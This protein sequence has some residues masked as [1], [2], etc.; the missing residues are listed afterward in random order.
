MMATRW[1]LRLRASATVRSCD[2]APPP[3]RGVKL[4]SSTM[5]TDSGL[6][7]GLGSGLAWSPWAARAS[8]ASSC[9]DI[10]AQPQLQ[11]QEPP[12]IVGMIPAAT[13][14]LVEEFG[15]EV[16]LEPAAGASTR[17]EQRVGHQR[18]E[19]PGTSHPHADG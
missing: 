4:L 13:L 2:S 5:R 1:P 18:L 6:V 10:P 7:A 8:P 14:V 3:P 17:V 19:A 9:I 15:D 11:H 12:E 16:G